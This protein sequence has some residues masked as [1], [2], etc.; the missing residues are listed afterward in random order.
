MSVGSAS[1]HEGDSGVAPGRARLIVF[2]RFPEP[3]RAKTRL[4]GRLGADGAADLHREMTAHTLAQA[5]AFAVWGGAEVEVRYEGGDGA[6]MAGAFGGDLRYIPQGGGDLGDRLARAVE[7]AFR[8][9]AAAA[10]VIGSDCPGVTA[11]LLG[12]ALGLL[13][14]D[15]GRVVLGPAL[16]GGY[17]LIGLGRV[18]PELFAGIAWSTDRVLGET[19]DRARRVGLDVRML[20]PLADVDRPEDLGAWYAACDGGRTRTPSRP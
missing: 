16:D 11:D 18:A 20:E 13:Q 9:G 17:Y 10:L 8:A 7:A 6:R 19:V 1:P 12:R 5:R 4:I 2:T 15:A 14:G 3:G